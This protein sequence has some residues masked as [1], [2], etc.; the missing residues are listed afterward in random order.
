MLTRPLA[1]L[2]L[3]LAVVAP[4]RSAPMTQKNDWISLFDG[5]TLAGWRGYRKPD[6]TTTRWTIED[7]M[8]TIAAATGADTR[9]ALDL[10]TTDSYDSFE[11]TWEWRISEGGNSGVKYFV[12]AAADRPLKPAGQFNSSRI[13]VNGGRVEH[14]LN[15]TRVLAYE[16][17]SP[18]LIAAV[19]KSKFKG[20]ERFGKPVKGHV[21]LQDHGDRVWYRNIRIRNLGTGSSR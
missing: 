7:G 12:V 4:M 18:E 13:V 3:A 9:G 5:K 16:L 15:G 8:L 10:I 19:E 6:A 2:L 17:A 11:L 14:W 1:A 20:I 21:L